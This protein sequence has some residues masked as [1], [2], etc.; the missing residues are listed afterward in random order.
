MRR[1]CEFRCLGL[2]PNTVQGRGV[3]ALP[4]RS[5][6]KKINSI[7]AV[8]MIAGLLAT[9]AS[10]QSANTADEIADLRDR[11]A[12]LEAAQTSASRPRLSFSV[13]ESTEISLYGFVRAE[14]FVDF[15]FAQG[16][17]SR[18]GRVGDPEFATD[19]EFDTSV[20]VS[21]FGIRSTTETGIGT[22]GTQL[23]FDLFGSG[24]D[25]SSSPNLR[26]RHANVTINDSLLFGQF[27]TNFMPLVHYPTTADFN[28][29]VGI[30]FARVPQAR[31]TYN[32]G[33]GL[34]L[35]ASVEEQNGGGSDPIVTGAAFYGTDTFSVRAAVLAGEFESD[36]ADLDTTGFTLSGGIT[37]WA[38][39]SINATYVTGE[40]I[41]NLLIGGGAR[42]VGGV[43]NDADGFTVQ[44]RQDIGEKWNVGIAYGN[45]SYDLATQIGESE[46][47]FT[48]LQSI[49]LSAFYSP[50]DN[51]TYAIEYIRIE[52]EGPDGFDA[53][54]DRIGASV[55][56]SF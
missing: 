32:N 19:R 11:V 29:P 22:V 24:G 56:F 44:L 15:D 45:E 49:H 30:T 50:V 23:E 52:S 9:D 10:A 36:G 13:G 20:R 25:D 47:S 28:G 7:A 41:G 54:A 26:L 14:A 6:T 42:A 39:G 33:N 51:L 4:Q 43:A 21:R 55:T 27:W 1:T 48:D 17:L 53:S 37:P 2:W 18:A 5:W 40:G 31:Y 12:E 3:R 34:L 35:S 8:G 38:G 16:D 46:N